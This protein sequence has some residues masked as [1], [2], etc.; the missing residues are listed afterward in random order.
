MST[1]KFVL[2]KPELFSDSRQSKLDGKEERLRRLA[3]LRPRLNSMLR[4]GLSPRL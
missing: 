4:V 3:Q 1:L 2:K